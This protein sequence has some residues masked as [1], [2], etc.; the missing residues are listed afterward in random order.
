MAI[1]GNLSL[2][3]NDVS[4]TIETIEIVSIFLQMLLHVSAKLEQKQMV[5]IYHIAIINYRSNIP[6]IHSFFT[7][8]FIFSNGYGNSIAHTNSINGWWKVTLKEVS[9]ISYI[10]VYNRMDCCQQRLK[11]AQ[12]SL[13]GTLIGT[14][15]QIEGTQKYTMPVN[16]DGMLC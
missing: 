5:Q 9:Y 10:D 3:L 15:P 11:N 12:L 7:K 2:I 14:I 8:H 16:K 6:F 13:D 1:G 4:I